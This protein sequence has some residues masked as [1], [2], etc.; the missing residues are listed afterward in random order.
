MPDAP[1]PKSLIPE[2]IFFN[3]QCNHRGSG[4]NTEFD[5]NSAHVRSNR[6]VADIEMFGNTFIWQTL[7]Y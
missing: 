3:Q 2:Q 4:T 5:K 1:F 7:G 6:P